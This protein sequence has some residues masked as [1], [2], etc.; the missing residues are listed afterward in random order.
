MFTVF[1]QDNDFI[2]LSSGRNKMLSDA[3]KL[4]LGVELTV[5]GGLH[6]HA[7]KFISIDRTGSYIENDFDSKFMGIYF[8]LSVQHIFVKDTTYLNKI[9][10]VKTYSFT[11]L[12]NEE[13]I[14]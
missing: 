12:K 13:D 11:D 8:I 3:L 5:Q 2:R 9:V 4:N 14:A 7:G 1:D 6:R 10:A